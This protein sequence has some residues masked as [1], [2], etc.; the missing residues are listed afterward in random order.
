MLV[1]RSRMRKGDSIGM[2]FPSP[3]FFSEKLGRKRRR[4][5]ASLESEVSHAMQSGRYYIRSRRT[6]L[7]S[8]CRGLDLLGI[9][10]RTEISRY[11]RDDEAAIA[12]AWRVTG[13]ALRVSMRRFAAQES[14]DVGRDGAAEA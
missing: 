12:R 8:Y 9:K 10:S 4:W 14:I 5:F 7:G 11:M 3:A 6:L 1:A 2:T 13:K